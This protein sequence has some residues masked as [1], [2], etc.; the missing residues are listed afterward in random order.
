MRSKRLAY[1]TAPS[2]GLKRPSRSSNTANA[3]SSLPFIYDGPDGPQALKWLEWDGA[4]RSAERSAAGRSEHRTAERCGSP[5]YLS[6]GDCCSE[7]T[8]EEGTEDAPRYETRLKP[9][10]CRKW[11]CRDC[12]PRMGK[13]LRSKLRDRLSALRC[14]FGITLTLDGSLFA[15]P[16]EGWRYVM[17]N[18]LLSVF[19]KKL[20][21][22]GYLNSRD[23]FW[24]VEW[25]QDTQ[26]A[27][28]HLLVDADC[29]PFGEL[30]AV[31]SSF[32]PKSAEPLPYRVTA[33]N[34]KTLDRPAFG[35]V[36]YTLSSKNPWKA[37]GY[38]TKYLV[39][40]PEYGFPDWVL[41]YDGR[42]PRYGHSKGFFAKLEETVESEPEP[43]GEVTV[44]PKSFT[45]HQADCFCDVC[46][47]EVH[48]ERVR[49][50]EYR[51]LRERLAQCQANS[52]LVSV[53]VW[54][55]AD[56]KR[57]E[58]KPSFLRSVQVPFRLACAALDAEPDASEVKL[59]F[60]DEL[61]LRRL[62]MDLVGSWENNHGQEDDW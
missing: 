50:R 16:V 24:V 46:R 38:A 9:C 30:V 31:W 41:D 59:N 48:D 34:Y 1:H 52:T 8:I 47:G 5:L 6:S 20:H 43:S 45:V 10:W 21:E 51:T 18:R 53:P 17:D 60:A 3:A 32:R 56:G 15:S 40:V 13:G 27:H 42:V 61:T 57:V 12:A 28:W 22:K 26:Q 7:T 62:E 29:I 54:R 23:Y 37:S 11:Y 33:E 14:V 19:V 44:E 25:Q 4:A 55:D 58:G 35:S 36:R 49:R 39:K 2:A